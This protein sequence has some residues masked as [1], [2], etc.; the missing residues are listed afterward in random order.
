M[1]DEEDGLL[2]QLLPN[3]VVEDVVPHMGIEGAKWIVQYVDGAVTVQGPGKADALP[4]PPTEV[5][6]T[7]PDL[8]SQ[9]GRGVGMGRRTAE[10]HPSLHPPEDNSVTSVRS[11]Q[12]RMARS[13]LKQQE[14]STVWYLS[15][16]HE[17]Q[18]RPRQASI[19]PRK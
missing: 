10:M 5:G 16:G 1:G 9:R 7:V 14:L 13:G 11:P 3:G 15:K 19:S 18:V 2:A 4:L 6:T 12:G 17:G 8:P